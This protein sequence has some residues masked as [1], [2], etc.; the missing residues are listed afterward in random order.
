MEWSFGLWNNTNSVLETL[1]KNTK[2]TQ[3]IPQQNN[4][5]Y[6]AT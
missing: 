3:N 5:E 2:H 4:I 1:I 6:L